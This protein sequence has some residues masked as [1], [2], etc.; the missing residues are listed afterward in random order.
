M[1]RDM[2]A[3]KVIQVMVHSVSEKPDKSVWRLQS[4][5][6]PRQ[7]GDGEVQAEKGG[8]TGRQRQH[9]RILWSRMA[10]HLKGLRHTI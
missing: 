1:K 4:L 7:D 5:V 10:T 2:N 3:K 6:R 9:A 8:R